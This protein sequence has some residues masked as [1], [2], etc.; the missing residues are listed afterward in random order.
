MKIFV[1]PH[2]LCESVSIGDGTRVSAF[3]HVVA[4]A[5]LG[6]NCQLDDHALVEAGAVIGNRVRIGSGVRVPTGVHIEDDVR[7]GSNVAFA[8]DCS[9]T[10]ART[11][12]NDTQTLIRRGASIGAR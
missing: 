12:R 2:A 6:A 3:V 11:H 5:K 8:D 7:V 9:K 1:H 10:S 4:G